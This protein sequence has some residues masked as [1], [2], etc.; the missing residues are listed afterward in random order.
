MK[1]LPTPSAD[2]ARLDA[3]QGQLDSAMKRL[4]AQE[5]I[6]A[7]YLQAYAELAALLNTLTEEVLADY[8][9]DKIKE[10][11]QKVGQ[12]QAQL[13]KVLQTTGEEVRRQD[14]TPPPS[15]E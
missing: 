10:F 4:D 5:G 6:I 12:S 3:M 13:W 15:A 1:Q 7:Q 11:G 9:Q 14:Q 8:S 2:A